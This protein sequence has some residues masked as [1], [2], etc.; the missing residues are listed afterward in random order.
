M[1]AAR[2]HSAFFS[3]FAFCFFFSAFALTACSIFMVMMGARGPMAVIA[4]CMRS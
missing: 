2:N 4:K 3:T 1:S